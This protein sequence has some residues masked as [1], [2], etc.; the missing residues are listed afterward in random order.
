M[1]SPSPQQ[2]SVRR[3]LDITRK[4]WDAAR[5]EVA[6][7][8]QLHLIAGEHQNADGT[9][10]LRNARL[11]LGLAGARYREALGDFTDWVLRR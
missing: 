3:R 2:D 8:D 4:E 9:Q 5:N 10:A 11:R 6:A 7:W 1:S